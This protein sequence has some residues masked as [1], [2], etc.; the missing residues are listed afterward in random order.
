MDR[1]FGVIGCGIA[2]LSSGIAAWALYKWCSLKHRVDNLTVNKYTTDNAVQQQ[3]VHH[4]VDIDQLVHLKSILPSS[5]SHYH[6]QIAELC[7]TACDKYGSPK[8]RVLDVGCSVGAASFHL[9][10]H[11]TDVL[12]ADTSYEML[13]AGQQLKHHSEM[14]ST[15][16]SEGG[17]YMKLYN[18]KIPD[19][20]QKDHVE[21]RELDV[22]SLKQSG[23][24]NCVLVSNT[25]TDLSDPISFLRSL[26]EVVDSKGILIISD[27]F[28]WP[29]GPEEK[30]SCDGNIKTSAVLNEVLGLDWI[31]KETL[32]MEW[33][34]PVS[35]RVASVASSEVTVWQKLP[36]MNPSD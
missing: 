32:T 29:D 9:S 12:G 13:A 3:L 33:C 16:S 36:C 14:I 20:A 6:Q 23:A 25:L 1:N 5:A 2:V 10:K 27:P 30:L 18:V 22:C 7:S 31:R 21:F 15:L 4:Y 24:F 34:M 8:L 26:A 11:F 28:L 17:K 35:E 19:G